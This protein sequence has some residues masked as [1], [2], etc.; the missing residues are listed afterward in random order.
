MSLPDGTPFSWTRRGRCTRLGHDVP[1]MGGV[2]PARVVSEM[3]YDPKDIVPFLFAE[4]DPGFHE[5]C[6]PGDVIV[7]GRNFGMG[8]KMQGYIAMQALGLGLVCES[9]PFLAYR[10]AVGLGLPVL[11]DCPGISDA[12]ATGDEVE[13]DFLAGRFVNHTRGTERAVP[14]VPAGLREIIAL[15][16]TGNWLRRWWQRQGAAERA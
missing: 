3:R 6:R 9:M 2:V 10:E 4:T 11:T 15:G 7:T 16:G 1:H 13:V 14:A 8:P 12:C 5:R